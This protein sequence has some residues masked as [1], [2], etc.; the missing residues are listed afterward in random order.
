MININIT[1]KNLSLYEKNTLRKLLSKGNNRITDDLEQ[2]WYLMDLIWD[3]YGCDNRNLDWDKIGKFYSHPVWLLNGLFIEQHDVSMG[4][5]HA[6]SDWVIKNNFKKVVDYG[7][8]FGTL[9]RLIAQKAPT[10]QMKIFEPHPSEFGLKRAEEFSNIEIIDTLDKKYNC[11]VSTDV[12]EHVPDP[13]KYFSNMIESVEVKGYLVIANHFS[14]VI[15]CHLPQT[16]HLKNTFNFFAKMMGLDVEGVLDGS[17]ATIYKKIQKKNNWN[18]V[19][20]Y[21]KL[22]KISY[23]IIETLKPILRP[24]KRALVK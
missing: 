21:E 20:F 19:R 6:I 5:R 24:I 8:G 14:P 15:K 18:K 3:D 12:L 1:D 13:L 23:P 22:S 2:M 7:G 4:H 16:F 11:L 17:H 10:T 9:A